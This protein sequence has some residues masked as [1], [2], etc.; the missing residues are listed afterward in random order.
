MYL[1]ISRRSLVR[2]E[3][4]KAMKSGCGRW[5]GA[6]DPGTELVGSPPAAEAAGVVV[7]IS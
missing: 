1:Y 2:G 7:G 5:R 3:A 6:Q 4:V